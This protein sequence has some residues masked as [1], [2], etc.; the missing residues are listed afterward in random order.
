MKGKQ[1]VSTN[2]QI[3]QQTSPQ[4]TKGEWL[5]PVILLWMAAPGGLDDNTV[6]E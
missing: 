2:K 4:C 3:N 5:P 6:P 1:L